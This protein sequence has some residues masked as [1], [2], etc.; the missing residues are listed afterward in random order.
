MSRPQITL[1]L[2]YMSAVRFILLL[3]V[4]CTVPLAQAQYQWLD[5]NGRRVYSDQ[6]PPAD[7]PEEYIL[8]WPGGARYAP[9]TKPK[10][11]LPAHPNPDT[12]ATS[13]PDTAAAAE[14]IAAARELE[15]RRH[16]LQA[17]EQAQQQALAAKQ[18]AARADNCTRARQSMR[19]LTSGMRIT[20]VNEA[21]RRVTLDDAQRKAEIQRA[22]Q[23]I[24]SDCS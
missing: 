7:I 23:V 21:G 16:Q 4:T 10:A 24:A 14:A 20:R 11:T 22:E 9:A 17:Q 13:P 12:V 19:N 18:R 5:H 6:M 3:A 15:Q 1:H 8:K 2:P